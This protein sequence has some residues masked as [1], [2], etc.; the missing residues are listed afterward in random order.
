MKIP[1]LILTAAL[2]LATNLRAEKGHEEHSHGD[3]KIAGPHGGRVI[4]LA[5][6]HLEFY[7]TS[8][9]LIEVY[10]YDSSMEP[11]TSSKAQ[12]QVI[13]QSEAGSQKYDLTLR[14]GAFRSSDPLPEG[15][16][17]P[18]VVRV[19]TTPESSFQNLRFLYNSSICGGCNLAEYA[20]TCEGHDH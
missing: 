11:S 16:N 1:T 7:A 4:E 8:E 3:E 15:N 13:A 2:A 6:G 14:E 5:E 18:L 17:Y 12:I 9:R 19:K 10:F 20:C